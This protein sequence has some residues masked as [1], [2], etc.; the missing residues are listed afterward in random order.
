MTQKSRRHNPYLAPVIIT[1]LTVLYAV[2]LI[3]IML[4]YMR[5]GA[6]LGDILLWGGLSLIIY[7]A[8]I[9]GVLIALHQR[10]REIQGGEEDEARQ[11]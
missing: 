11:Y 10:V 2:G 6:P 1:I 5:S 3:A 4:C 7:G 8:I 9:V